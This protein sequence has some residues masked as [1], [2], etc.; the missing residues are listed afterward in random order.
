MGQTLKMAMS[1]LESLGITIYVAHGA[2]LIGVCISPLC[3]YLRMLLIL[4][5]F[6]HLGVQPSSILLLFSI[7]VL[8]YTTDIYVSTDLCQKYKPKSKR[9][10]P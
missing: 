3:L 6:L 2:P 4:P 8:C 1:A 9:T 10:P 7:Q 5:C